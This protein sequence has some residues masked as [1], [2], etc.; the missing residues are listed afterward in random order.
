M[1]SSPIHMAMD[2]LKHLWLRHHLKIYILFCF[3]PWQKDLS[4]MWDVIANKANCMWGC[5][6]RS[7]GSRLGWVVVHLY[8]LLERLLSSLE[9]SSWSGMLKIWRG[10]RGGAVKDLEHMACKKRLKELCLLSPM[11]RIQRSDPAAA[12]DYCPGLL[13]RWQ[14][15][16]LLFRWQNEMPWMYIMDWQI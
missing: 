8:S 5:F 14:I 9:S 1:P 12:C 3:I 10:S 4:P 2:I 13:Q 15:Q 16:M 11:E 6:R 7:L